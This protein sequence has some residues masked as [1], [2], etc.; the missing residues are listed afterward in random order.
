MKGIVLA[1]GSGSRLF[2]LTLGTSKQLLAIYDKPMIYYPLSTLMSAKIKDILIIT[3][4]FDQPSFKRLLGDGSD[5]GINLTYAIQ[6]NPEGI[7]QALLIAEDFIGSDNVC[8]ILGDNIFYGQD[9]SSQLLSAKKRADNNLATI[10]C[11][12]VKDPKRFGIVE[13]NEELVALSIEEK[14]EKPKSNYAVTG[15]YFYDNRAVQL[16]KTIEPSLRGELEITSLNQLYLED[17]TLY[18]NKLG[19]GF[20]W[21][22]TGTHQTLY[23]ASVFIQSLEQIHGHKVACLE[24]ISWRNRWFSDEDLLLK[25]KSFGTN[26]YGK[27]LIELIHEKNN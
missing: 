21:L 2:P 7:A 22:D 17:R 26:N 3:T 16:A 10:F 11:S 20:T 4:P 24:E 15:L 19:R 6:P 5:F 9:F 18:V 23:D 12:K 27:Y 25:A 14:P 1:G 13:F 8:L